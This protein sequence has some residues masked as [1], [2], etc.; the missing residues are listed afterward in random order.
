MTCVRVT[1]R[2]QPVRVSDE[3]AERLEAA[4]L[5]R[6]ASARW[7]TVLMQRDMTHG[8]R[9]WVSLRRACLAC[10]QRHRCSKCRARPAC[11]ER[12]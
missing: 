12:S 7:L 2:I 9:E 3:E 1:N 6:R 11:V 4:G 8:Q 10:R 5:W